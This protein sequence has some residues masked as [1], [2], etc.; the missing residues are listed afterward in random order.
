[1]V[2]VNLMAVGYIL[3]FMGIYLIYEGAG[4]IAGS[5]DR[6]RW[7]EHGRVVRIIF[8]MIMLALGTLFI[9]AISQQRIA[10]RFSRK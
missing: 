4:S 9:L 6:A 7:S 10:P 8:A 5:K 1:M 3:S 2:A